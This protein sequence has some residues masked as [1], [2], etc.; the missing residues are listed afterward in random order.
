MTHGEVVSLNGGRLHL[1]SLSPWSY[2]YSY[3]RSLLSLRVYC[4]CT[5]TSL[6]LSQTT[7]HVIVRLLRRGVVRVW[8]TSGFGVGIPIIYYYLL[9]FDNQFFMC[10]V[11][12]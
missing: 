9:Q 11:F 4:L 8:Q 10:V 6:L 5:W 7:V 1:C 3:E 2:W 12:G